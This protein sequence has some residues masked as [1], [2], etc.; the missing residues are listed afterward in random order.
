MLL[1]TALALIE[2]LDLA[3][4]KGQLKPKITSLN[5]YHARLINKLS[6]LPVNRHDL[7]SNSGSLF[8]DI[9]KQ[10]QPVRQ[11]SPR[12]RVGIKMRIHPDSA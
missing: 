2:T 7:H 6:Y 8:T 1:P 5:K 4:I 10:D 12:Q 9:D 11:A 3:E